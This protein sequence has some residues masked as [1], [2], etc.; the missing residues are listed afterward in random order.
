[1]LDRFCASAISYCI[2]L[3]ALGAVLADHESGC[4]EVLASARSSLGSDGQAEVDALLQDFRWAGEQC[5]CCER[6]AALGDAMGGGVAE[7]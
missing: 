5:G 7:P 1:M 6:L 2:A 4:A 3:P